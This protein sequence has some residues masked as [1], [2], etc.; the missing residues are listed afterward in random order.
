MAFTGTSDPDG[1]VIC[2]GV[3]RTNGTDG[4]YNCLIA[5]SIGTGTYNSTY[6][7]PNM[8]GVFLRGTG[9]DPTNNYLGPSINTT[10]KHATQSHY[11]KT[12]SLT[13]SDPGHNHTYITI[14]DDFNSGNGTQNRWPSF[15]FGDRPDAGYRV[16]TSGSSTGITSATASIANNTTSTSANETRP[17]NLGINWIIKY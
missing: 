1:W 7:P 6:T 8:K 5:T 9:T 16:N 14:N 13:L 10:Q 3:Q 12:N 11:H 15:S 17:Y 4:R 2:D